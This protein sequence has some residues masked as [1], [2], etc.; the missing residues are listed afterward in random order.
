MP[1]AAPPAVPHWVAEACLQQ[2]FMALL[3]QGLLSE[4]DTFEHCRELALYSLQ[5]CEE[6]K[7][8]LLAEQALK[9]S[10]RRHCCVRSIS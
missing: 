1:A 7:A 8:K 2:G 6:L 9:G 5:Q 10:R 4:L 3:D